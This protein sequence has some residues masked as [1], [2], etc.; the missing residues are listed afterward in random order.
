M[1][2]LTFNP[3]PIVDVLWVLLCAALVMLM[4]G[5]F[6]CLET[7]LVRAKN[8]INVAIKNLVDFCI[9]ALGFWIIGFAL[10]FGPTAAGLVGTAGFFFN[11]HNQP[12]LWAFFFF[13]MVFCGTAT[14]LVSGAVAERMRFTGYLGTSLIVSILI[15]PIIGHWMW[16]G[17]ASGQTTGWLNN[18]GFIDY[19]G[20]TVVHSV[21][22]WVALA[23]VIIIGP[24]IGRFST[25]DRPSQG[26]NIPLATLGVLI[27]W[28]GWYGFNG[29]S[30][31]QFSPKVPQ[32]FV[33]T[34]LAGATGA[35][36]ALGL[37]WYLL[38]RPGV[39]HA[40]NGALAGLVGITASANIMSPEG[41]ILIGAGAGIIC[42]GATLLLE[43]LQID[44][45]IGIVP[46][47]ACAGVW[48]TIAFPLLSDP[49]NWGTGLTRG[50]QFAIQT[51]GS[52]ICF[53]WAFGM[54]FALLWLI[55]RWMPLR[56]TAEEEH[57]GLNMAEH[58]AS[59]A[60]VDLLGQMKE[61]RQTKDFSGHVQSDPHTEMGQIAEEY[62]QV[63]DTIN[64]EQ[65]QRQQ[66]DDHIQYCASL[67]SLFQ[68]IAK[69]TNEPSTVEEVMQVSMDL[70]CRKIGWPIGHLYLISEG[71]GDEL[72]STSVWHLEHAERYQTFRHITEQ[73][74]FQVG[75][76]L[77]GRVLATG[78][79]NWISDVT[80]DANF[81]RAKLAK[82]IGVKAGFAFPILIEEHVVGV[83]EFFS[84]R[85]HRTGFQ[86]VRSH[87]LC[88]LATWSGC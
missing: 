36:A 56:V 75:V 68:Q 28:F 81:P 16:G 67:D 34:T 20:S 26:Q 61:Q 65:Q 41:T 43:R 31:F 8:S 21:G 11:A 5:G 39:G 51:L 52:G 29:G 83:L 59:T 25:N 35:V 87:G 4:Q 9:S 48:G 60:I 85:A 50:E 64:A 6:T 88:R 70:I 19:A 14:T 86:I 71:T 1:A 46:V 79:P 2:D 45:A 12:W 72:I 33:N 24:R 47:H 62:N 40:L 54:S 7:G 15:Y 53:V 13:Q 80:K 73:T 76:G 18:L 49:A 10:M 17:L 32:I 78:K 37:S 3:S 57:I 63:L 77:P 82:D 69:T 42:V 55:N 74:N 84:P 30:T 27:L 58:G 22:G 38:K 23:A 66:M 44:D